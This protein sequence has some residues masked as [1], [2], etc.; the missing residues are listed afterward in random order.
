MTARTF[1]LLLVLAMVAMLFIGTADDR[2]R[3]I[4]AMRLHGLLLFG[5]P[6]LVCGGV[7]LLC[8]RGLPGIPGTDAPRA[9]LLL[10]LLLALLTQGLFDAGRHEPNISRRLVPL[11][12]PLIAVLAGSGYAACRR[13]GGWRAR[14]AVMLLG[15]G[16]LWSL[17]P[18]LPFFGYSNYASLNPPLAQAAA[19]LP[20]QAILIVDWPR[21]LLD[22]P[23]HF[24]H[25]ITTVNGDGLTAAELAALRAY[26]AT[27]HRRLFL[28]R[29]RITPASGWLG[30]VS[31]L[32]AG[33]VLPHPQV[34]DLPLVWEDTTDGV[35]HPRRTAPL[36]VL[37][38]LQELP[39]DAAP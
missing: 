5:G 29:S 35:R 13:A 24:H 7:L 12:L 3:S 4:A 15:G 8:R 33:L 25:G 26:A 30:E 2:Y 11:V 34:V 21:G 23:L 9:A 31:P 6:L 18:S 27:R 14:L 38:S 1:T 39:P 10:L 16:V 28:L 36:R 37:L 32:L 20:P 22:T 19:A 17:I